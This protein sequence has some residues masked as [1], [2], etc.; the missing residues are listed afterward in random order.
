MLLTNRKNTYLLTNK[1]NLL[2][3]IM[4]VTEELLVFFWQSNPADRYHLMPII[5]PAYPQQNSTFNVSFS[6]RTIMKEEFD[7]GKWKLFI[8]ITHDNQPFFPFCK[9]I[10]FIT[11]SEPFQWNWQNHE[12]LKYFRNVYCVMTNHS[13]DHYMWTTVSVKIVTNSHSHKSHFMPFDG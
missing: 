8:L 2:K 6:T 7:I 11:R 12:H 10:I 9:L 1:K 3:L 13:K 5:T 4:W